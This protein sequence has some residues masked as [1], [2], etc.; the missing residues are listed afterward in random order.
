MSTSTQRLPSSTKRSAIAAPIPLAAP[1]TT[2][3]CPSS[4]ALMCSPH[5]GAERCLCVDSSPVGIANHN[6][7]EMGE[8]GL[9][10]TPQAN[11]VLR[12][13]VVELER[14]AGLVDDLGRVRNIPDLP[15]DM[16]ITSKHTLAEVV[17]EA[18]EVPTTLAVHPP[19][20]GEGVRTLGA[21]GV[22]QLVG[23]ALD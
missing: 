6:A 5:S 13:V 20:I 18:T 19:E 17:V 21:F 14:R 7:L 11:E 3:T 15:L 22:G 4:R 16:V 12:P 10:I 8:A 1:V 23:P 2:A 9:A